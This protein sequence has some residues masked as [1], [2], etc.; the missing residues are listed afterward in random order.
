VKHTRG[1]ASIVSALL[2]AT[3][4]LVASAPAQ[5]APFTSAQVNIYAHGTYVGQSP[6]TYSQNDGTAFTASIRPAD[7]AV[8]V[9]WQQSGSTSQSSLTLVGPGGVPITTGTYANASSGYQHEA[10]RPELDLRLLDSRCGATAR[11][12][13]TVHKLET[14]PG[15]TVT[16]LDVSFEHRCPH[17]DSVWGAT[18]GRLML[19]VPAPQVIPWRTKPMVLLADSLPSDPAKIRVFPES[20]SGGPGVSSITA[21]VY[22]VATGL[23][24]GSTSNFVYQSPSSS[25]AFGGYYVSTDRMPLTALGQYRIDTEVTDGYGTSSQPNNGYLTI[26]RQS[27]MDGVALDRPAVDYDHT[28][29]TVSGVLK[30][31]HQGTGAITPISGATVRL[32]ATGNRQLA[33]AV[34]AAN[35][36]FSLPVSHRVGLGAAEDDD[37]PGRVVA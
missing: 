29:A 28:S 14:G 16:A 36:S 25:N 35:G 7:S 2:A 30:E 3:A 32:K 10:W 11:S 20:A 4:S 22:S 27:F 37:A 9:N 8:V 15:N 18:Y 12:N 21:R 13:F 19:N 34:T 23:L 31:K 1:L 24:T 5:A 17:E 26:G 6:Q 33:T